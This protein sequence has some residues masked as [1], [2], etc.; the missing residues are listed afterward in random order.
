MDKPHSPMI[1]VE[2][3]LSDNVIDVIETLV[4]NHISKNYKEVRNIILGYNSKTGKWI[5]KYGENLTK[6]GTIKTESSI[7]FSLAPI[8]TFTKNNSMI[9]YDDEVYDSATFYADE[10][11]RRILD[12]LFTISEHV[13]EY[14]RI[15]DI[16][17]TEWGVDNV[18]N[19][20]SLDDI[21]ISYNICGELHYR[22]L[23]VRRQAWKKFKNIARRRKLNV[24]DSFKL[25]VIGFL[26]NRSIIL[27]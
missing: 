27:K 2:H 19:S 13:I 18:R 3:H 10:S 25:A 22:R 8:D 4:N 15:I 12:M 16:I 11:V 23:Y 24:R 26:E 20:I 5:S 21:D 17:I 6:K 7:H 9:F 14:A 1:F